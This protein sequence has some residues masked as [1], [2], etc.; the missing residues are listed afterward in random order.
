MLPWLDFLLL[1]FGLAALITGLLIIVHLLSQVINLIVG[2]VEL[3]VSYS[4]VPMQVGNLFSS[5]QQFSS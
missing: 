3:R 2:T 5:S 1:A 4:H